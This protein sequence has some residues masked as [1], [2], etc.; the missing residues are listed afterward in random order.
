[1]SEQKKIDQGGFAN[2]VPHRLRNVDTGDTFE[3]DSWPSET[4]R[5]KLAGLAMQ[6]LLASWIQDD[7]VKFQS[8][9][10]DDRMKMFALHA[11]QMAD[12]MIAYERAEAEVK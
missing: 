9:T 6:G 3:F 11:H 10:T 5:Q 1:M 7:N 2:P 12:A 8:L 4:R